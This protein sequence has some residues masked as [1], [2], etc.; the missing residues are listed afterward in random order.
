MV[1][2]IG[3]SLLCAN[4]LGIESLT[5]LTVQYLI[6]TA[7]INFYSINIFLYF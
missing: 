7:Y 6:D 2:N 1:L 3:G 5:F 4:T